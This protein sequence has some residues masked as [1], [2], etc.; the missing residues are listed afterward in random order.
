MRSPALIFAAA[1]LVLGA[2]LIALLP[3]DAL[4]A[5][6]GQH[7]HAAQAAVPGERWACPMMDFI[8][9]KP[10]DCPVCGM[11]MTK[12]TAGELSREQQ[13]RMDVQ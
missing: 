8:G 11:K 5:V 7:D 1:G 10:G 6:S 2:G 13:R 9:N 4:F 3:R 12:V